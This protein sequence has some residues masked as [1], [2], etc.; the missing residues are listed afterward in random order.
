MVL[1]EFLSRQNSNDRN[2]HEIIPISF[3]IYQVLNE[4]YYNTENYLVETRSQARSSG[5]KPPEVNGM[6]K[7]LV[8][9]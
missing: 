7:N 8:P 5:I 9:T 3:N 6:G 1:S 4:K 2:P